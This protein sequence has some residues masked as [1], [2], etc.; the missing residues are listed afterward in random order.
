MMYD[1]DKINTKI[2]IR[3]ITEINNS[4][5]P[6]KEKSKY[7]IYKAS[8][9]DCQKKITAVGRGKIVLSSHTHSIIGKPKRNCNDLPLK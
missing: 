3:A 9:I 6:V 5:N 7:Q 1:S 8:N 4:L 2:L